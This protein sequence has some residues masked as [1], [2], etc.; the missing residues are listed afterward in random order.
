MTTPATLSASSDFVRAL[1]G[2]TSASV[3]LTF[4]PHR[5]QSAALY[6]RKLG[7]D[8]ANGQWTSISNQIS[9]GEKETVTDSL[10]PGDVIQYGVFQFPA[11]ANAGNP[12]QVDRTVCCLKEPSEGEIGLLDQH[13]D[14]GGTYADLFA[15][16][17]SRKTF[18][19]AYAKPWTG[20]DR[21]STRLNSSH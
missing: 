16:S 1:K 8:G 11:E 20:P 15:N 9:P 3:D 21:K 4:K 17:G 2:A 7:P 14:G 12:P 13:I 5:Q 18:L 6:K 19:R 10:S